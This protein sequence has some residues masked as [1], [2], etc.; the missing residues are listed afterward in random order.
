MMISPLG[1]RDPNP[2]GWNDEES[3]MTTDSEEESPP[4]PDSPEYDAPLFT[5]QE[6]RELQT[7][8]AWCKALENNEFKAI[9]PYTT[10]D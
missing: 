10:S 1:P 4:R 8:L 9:S 6:E 2:V 3:E 5:R 7:L